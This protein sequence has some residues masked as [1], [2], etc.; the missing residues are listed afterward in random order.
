[1]ILLQLDKAKLDRRMA[2]A[3]YDSYDAI[4]EAARKRGKKLSARTI[5]NMLS[6]ENW[7]REK[8]EALCLV[9]NCQPADIVSGWQSNGDGGDTHTHVT[10]QSEQEREAEPT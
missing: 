7:S 5:Y 9:L 2:L 4:A 8:L 6:G 1:M 10:P 3:H